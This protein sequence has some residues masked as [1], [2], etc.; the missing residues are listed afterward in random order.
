M[1]EQMENNQPHLSFPS[2]FGYSNSK[3]KH[4]NY[5]NQPYIHS[6]P[7]AQS[8]T[9]PTT[10]GVHFSRGCQSQVVVTIR[11]GSNLYNVSGSKTLDQLW[12]LKG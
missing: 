6:I 3:G 9:I 5:K 11:M 12:G 8:S 4:V 1:S 7:M 10:P 2:H